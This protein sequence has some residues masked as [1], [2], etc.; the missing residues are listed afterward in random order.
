MPYMLAVL[1]WGFCPPPH[2]KKVEKETTFLGVTF[3]SASL[4]DSSAGY[5]VEIDFSTFFLGNLD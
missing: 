1:S 2:I 5:K 4:C 3:C